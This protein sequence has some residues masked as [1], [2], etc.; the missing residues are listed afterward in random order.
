MKSSLRSPTPTTN[1]PKASAVTAPTSSVAGSSLRTVKSLLSRK[2][3]G[4]LKSPFNNKA[5]RDNS[6]KEIRD[7]DTQDELQ[8]G[9]VSEYTAR[10]APS[11]K[12][13]QSSIPRPRTRYYN[14]NPN[15]L[16]DSDL[17][18]RY[19]DELRDRRKLTV[20]NA[21][22]SGSSSESD[23]DSRKGF[24]MDNRADPGRNWKPK[25][26]SRGTVGLGLSLPLNSS[27]NGEQNEQ[28]PWAN[29]DRKRSAQ[30]RKRK[31]CDFPC[32]YQNLL[33]LTTL[34]SLT[35]IDLTRIEGVTAQATSRQTMLG[36]GPNSW[37]LSKISEHLRNLRY[38]PEMHEPTRTTDD[39]TRLKVGSRAHLP[40]LLHFPV[41]HKRRAPT[42]K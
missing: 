42:K 28:R 1:S 10:L 9:L 31:P 41:R 34:A 25:Q 14:D 26:H 23:A 18:R 2:Y 20:T 5:S 33:V 27:L 35:A 8:A 36:D 29:S 12:I 37:T 32:R 19:E 39:P 11:N 38:N 17:E 3:S 7:A 6:R 13:F 22:V 40:A 24:Y 16:E 21:E 4:T 30:V 15:R